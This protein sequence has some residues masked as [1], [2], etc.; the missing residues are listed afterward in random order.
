MTLTDDERHQLIESYGTAHAQLVTALARYS[1]A[2]WKERGA[3]GWSIHEIM[4]HITDSEANSYI[5]L[6][7]LIAEP[8]SMVLGYDENGWATALRYQDQDPDA[9]LEL[10]RLLRSASYALL[11]GLP[12]ST[13]AHTVEHSENGTMTLDDW[14]RTYERHIPDHIAQ[15]DTVYRD[16]TQETPV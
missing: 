13:W 7:R 3:E 12:A 16:L 2:R 1:R 14:L 10:F 15:M 4:V 6:R 8:G 9:A 5:R 11:Q